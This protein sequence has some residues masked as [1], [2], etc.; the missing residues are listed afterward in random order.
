MENEP[1]DPKPG[2]KTTEFWLSTAAC[3]VGAVVA[4]GVVP[5]ESAGERILGLIV[6]VLAAL[7]YT[8]SRLA[9][10]RDRKY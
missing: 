8:G 1:S 4:S 6:S 7:G 3:L 2:Y 10:K 9:L 5:A